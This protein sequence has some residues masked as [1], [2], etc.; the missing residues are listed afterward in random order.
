MNVIPAVPR[1]NTATFIFMKSWLHFDYFLSLSKD[2]C[3]ALFSS[4]TTSCPSC[5]A[6]S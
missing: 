1:P 5:L 4:L 3:K 6:L 2:S